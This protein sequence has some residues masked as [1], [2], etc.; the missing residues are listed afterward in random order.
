MKRSIR[1]FGVGIMLLSAAWIGPTS[2]G[3]ATGPYLVRNIDTTGSS[4][5]TEL[6]AVGETLFFSAKGGSK[7]RELWMSDGTESGTR[8]VKDNR[9]GPGGSTPWDLTAFGGMLLFTA[10]DGSTGREL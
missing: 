2:A 10:D 9:P 3:A 5:P 4:D 1:M 7:G 6:T 8:R